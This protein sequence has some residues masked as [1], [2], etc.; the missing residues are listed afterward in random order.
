[1]EQDYELEYHKLENNNWW[2]RARRDI[3]FRLINKYDKNCKILD[4]GCA[5][6]ET[7]VFLKKNGF[8]NIYGIDKS[9][10]AIKT[11]KRKGIKNLFLMDAT[12]IKL[13][14]K[15]DLIIASDVL[16]HIKNNNDALISWHNIIK[17]D[18]KLIL[19]VPAFSF[20][21]SKRDK[22][23]QHYLRYSKEKLF[24]DLENNGFEVKRI[25]YWNFISLFPLILMI[26][27]CKLITLI[28]KKEYKIKYEV[29]KIN[30][31]L[32][33]NIMRFENYIVSKGINIPIGVSIF[34]ISIKK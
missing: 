5:S 26:F 3:I 34:A 8:S 9:I 30:N 22:I 11:C 7:I 2:F 31:D 24:N 1:M 27:L 4:I 25:S 15:F 14:H 23:N 21:W 28:N 12:N 20:L 10:N 29:N 33:Y 6:G 16:E 13:N 19:F 18:G 32:L 17:K